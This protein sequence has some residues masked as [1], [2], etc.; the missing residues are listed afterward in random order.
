M[1]AQPATG[2]AWRAAVEFGIDVSQIEYLLTLSPAQRL[3][4]HDQALALVQAMRAAGIAHYG[5][6]PRPPETPDR[7]ER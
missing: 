7:P 6:D 1:A 2:S 5:Y 3:A 4:R